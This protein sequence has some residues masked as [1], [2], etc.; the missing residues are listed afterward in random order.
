MV[1]TRV[2]SRVSSVCG[3]LPG[4]N[5]L[6]VD[7]RLKTTSRYRTIGGPEVGSSLLSNPIIKD[8]D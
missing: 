5:S 1:R 4:K 8:K 6:S 7:T 3:H 2:S